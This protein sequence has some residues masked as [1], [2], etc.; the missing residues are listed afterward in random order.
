MPTLTPGAS[1]NV[2]GAGTPN[3]N[4]SCE[5]PERSLLPTLF[6]TPVLAVGTCGASEMGTCLQFISEMNTQQS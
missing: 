1:R 2:E 3:D 6:G 4:K 5:G